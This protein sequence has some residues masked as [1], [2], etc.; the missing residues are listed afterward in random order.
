MVSLSARITTALKT[1]IRREEK[2]SEVYQQKAKKMK[3]SKARDILESL[4]K[5]EQVHAVKIQRVLE[6]G[7]MAILGKRKGLSLFEHLSLRND[8]VRKMGKE[9]E[10]AKVIRDA[11]KAEENS[12]RFYTG[13]AK[14][15]KG[16]DVA[17][18]FTRLADEELKHKARLERVLAWL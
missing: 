8:D 9:T 15:S 11:V 18:L 17:D 2:T 4:S 7:D 10:A 1:A 14:I 12:Y 3:D 6:K 5:Q 16:L 13:L